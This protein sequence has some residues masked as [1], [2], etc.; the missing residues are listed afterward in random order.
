MEKLANRRKK[1]PFL[2]LHGIL[3][4]GQPGHALGFL[5]CDLA[6]SCTIGS[7]CDSV[8]EAETGGRNL[9]A[10]DILS[11][12]QKKLCAV[13]R[14]VEGSHQPRTWLTLW[15]GRLLKWP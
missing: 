4:N 10:L 14:S 2:Q 1:L 11:S 7:A 8:N 13:P 3:K 12:L 15:L 5:H 9:Q 6:D